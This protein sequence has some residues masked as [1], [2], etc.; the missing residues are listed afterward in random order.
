[1]FSI[2]GSQWLVQVEMVDVCE[3]R[4]Q[5]DAFHFDARKWSSAWTNQRLALQLHQLDVLSLTATAHFKR[6]TND[7][8]KVDASACLSEATIEA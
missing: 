2:I 7:D 5:D 4:V 1:M 8:H 3:S 6:N